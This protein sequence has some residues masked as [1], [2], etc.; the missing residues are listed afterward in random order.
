MGS[1][2]EGAGGGT[3][4]RRLGVKSGICEGRRMRRRVPRMRPLIKNEG[5][6]L[7]DD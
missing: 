5:R 6:G 2:D 7:E 3:G 1:Q 4:V